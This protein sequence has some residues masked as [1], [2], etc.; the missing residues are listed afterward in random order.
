MTRKFLLT[1]Q[2]AVEAGPG[3]AGGKGWNLGRLGRYGFFVPPG[4]VLSASAYRSFLQDNDLL[5]KTTA[6]AGITAEEVTEPKVTNALDELRAAILTG[7]LPKFAEQELEAFLCNNSLDKVAV[8]VRSS[9]T[10]EDS[11]EASFAGIHSSFL[12]VLG[13]EQMIE[14]ICGCYASLWTPQA[15]AYRRK[16]GFSDEDVAAAVVIMQ[17]VLSTAAGVAFS[18]DPKTGRQDVITISANFGLGESVVSGSV[19][20]DEYCLDITVR[21]P[22]VLE[23]R[24]GTKSVVVLP[25]AGGGTVT[26]EL[27]SEEGTKAVL[28]DAELVELANLIHRIF[29]ALGEGVEHQDVEW[30]FDGERFIVLQARPVTKLP[31]YTFAPVAHLPVIWSNANVKDAM[32]GAAKTLVWN[33]GRDMVDMLVRPTLVASGYKTPE[34]MTFFR[35]YKGRGYFNLTAGQWFAYDGLGMLPSELNETLGG[36]QPEIPIPDPYPLKG[37]EGRKRQARKMRL[38]LHVM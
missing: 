2:E 31:T 3:E 7:R 8:A 38:G 35:L 20:P 13:Y 15:L 22:K 32:P 29:Y 26:R 27:E 33:F 36:H 5:E 18:C 37:K 24:V 34:G 19:E 4:G 28:T 30:T 6:L 14:A 21:P 10:T 25:Q 16:M 1:W 17:M 11:R 12:N 9:A 23:K